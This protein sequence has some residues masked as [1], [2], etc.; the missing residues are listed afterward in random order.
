MTEEPT[1]TTFNDRA[2]HYA[3]VLNPLFDP[4][5]LMATD[6]FFEFVCVVVRAGG[7][8]GPEWDPWYESQA[9]LDDLGNLATL[10]LPTALFPNRNRTRMRLSL[11]SY[12]HITEMNFPYSLVVNLLRLRLGK[13]YHM[14]PF[15]DLFVPIGKK[16][17]GPIQDVRPP[18]PGKKISRIKR[19]AEDAKLPEVGQAFESIYDR[20][21]RNAVY[22]S[23][24]TL[25]DGEF[26]LL[27]GF[28]P[29]KDKGH[30]TPVVEWEQLTELFTNTFAFYTALFSLYERCLKSFGGFK[31]VF[32]PFDGQYKGILQ[33]VFD[34]DQRLSG[35][36]VYWPN[37]SLSE[38]KR[39]KSASGGINLEFD[40][41]GS[42]NFMVG[43]YATKPGD[44]SPL[45][46]FDC[47]P[48]YPEVPGTRIRPHWPQNLRT[49]KL[50]L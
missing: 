10:D 25:S 3:E 6:R 20:V 48:V 2:R 17:A 11:L 9:T 28:H 21:I 7:A 5:P 30:L 32:L 29:S 19:Y 18:S 43:V 41:D 45:A 13:K 23:D 34:E 46:E 15:A 31:D 22:H 35:F 33:L 36:R 37:N 44:F 50:P 1:G 49:Y 16:D 38:Y 12:C 47:Q 42:I 27:T 40:P 8:H 24:Y 14:S 39:V 4:T 26:R